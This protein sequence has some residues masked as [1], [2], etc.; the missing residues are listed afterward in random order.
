LCFWKFVFAKNL[1]R[2]KL[3]VISYPKSKREK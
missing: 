1:D 3:F 2:Q